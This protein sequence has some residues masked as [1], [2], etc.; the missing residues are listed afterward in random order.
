[1]PCTAET[2]WERTLNMHTKAT[3]VSDFAS[4]WRAGPALTLTVVA[5]LAL[6]ACGGDSG[7]PKNN[8]ANTAT[9]PKG[10]AALVA[11]GLQ[12]Q[13][14]GDLA[15]A[16][17][18][19]TQAIAD[20]PKNKFG[21]YDLGLI[22]QLAGENAAAE[23]NYRLALNIDPKFVQPLLAILR[24][25]AKSLPE[26]IDLYRRAIAAEPKDADAHFNLGLLL[27]QT[28]NVVAGTA[29]VQAAVKLDPTL[30][31]RAKAQGIPTAGK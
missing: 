28:G 13:A 23:N 11:K 5:V 1:M 15:G 3:N 10:A 4:W 22:Q 25:A 21:Y 19:Y 31:A 20:D 17:R 16:R 14:A 7:S 26:A 18:D 6:G 8:A 12:E 24:T 30:S 9:G 27:R 29:E 2:E